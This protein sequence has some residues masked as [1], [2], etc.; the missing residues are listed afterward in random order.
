[1]VY[2]YQPRIPVM[3]FKHTKCLNNCIIHRVSLKIQH[4]KDVDGAGRVVAPAQ[5]AAFPSPI[6]LGVFVVDGGG[7]KFQF[8]VNLLVGP[9]WSKNGLQILWHLHQTWTMVEK[10]LFLKLS[11]GL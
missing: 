5:A 7:D 1:M 6:G 2:Y 11:T 8:R 3:I 9:I 10:Y 4:F